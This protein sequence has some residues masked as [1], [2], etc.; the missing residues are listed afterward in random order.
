MK[1]FRGHLMIDQLKYTD[2]DPKHIET[3]MRQ[4]EDPSTI[5]GICFMNGMTSSPLP[6]PYPNGSTETILELNEVIQRQAEATESEKQF[7][8]AM[9]DVKVHY[10]MWADEAER[11]TGTKYGYDFMNKIATCGDGYLNYMKLIHAR[12]RPYQ[13]AP[14]FEKK[15]S[16]LTGDP[17]TGS[18]P[19]G[20]SYDAWLIALIL[21]MEHPDYRT[22]FMRIAN[23]VST[24]RMIAGVHFPSDLAAGKRLAI[25]AL[26]IIVEN[27]LIK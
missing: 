5:L 21:T 12:P 17:R 20:H 9:D 24:S 1:S 2:T 22:E 18:Y 8:V 7:T 19:S 14:M 4:K 6:S 26:N 3:V 11:I 10:Q 27:D 15:L 25:S 13:L 23:R 16:I